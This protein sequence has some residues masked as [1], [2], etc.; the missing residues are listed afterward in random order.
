MT[1]LIFVKI[2]LVQYDVCY[3][4]TVINVII[5]PYDSSMRVKVFGINIIIYNIIRKQL[6]LCNIIHSQL[7][8]S[9]SMVWPPLESDLKG[10]SDFIHK[11]IW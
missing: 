3:D 7:L 2:I 5:L 4:I 1:E 6:D 10:T 8:V 11:T 9:S